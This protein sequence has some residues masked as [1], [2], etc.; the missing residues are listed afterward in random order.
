MKESTVTNLQVLAPSRRAP[1]AGDIFVC[2]PA[3]RGYFFGRVV[4]TDAKIKYMSDSILI[5]VFAIESESK[6]PP[7]RLSIMRLLIPPLMTNRLP[8]SRGYFEFVA[9]RGFELGE[10]LPIHCFYSA[11]FGRLFDDDGNELDK[12][13]EPCGLSGLDS[14]RTIDDAISRALGIPLASS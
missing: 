9:N 13:V 2:R 11:A 6:V 8:W 4:R 14:Y 10:R 7:E 12:K 5:Y 1:R 3:G